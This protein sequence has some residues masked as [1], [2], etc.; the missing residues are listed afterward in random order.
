MLEDCQV[1]PSRATPISAIPVPST[2]RS[3]ERGLLASLK[4]SIPVTS[5]MCVGNRDIGD[6]CSAVCAHGADLAV[7]VS[8]VR[9]TNGAVVDMVGV[10]VGCG[11]GG[12]RG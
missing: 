2:C 8:P 10:A 7:T 4:T 5:R 1:K 3:P 6:M 9:G 12:P 11:H